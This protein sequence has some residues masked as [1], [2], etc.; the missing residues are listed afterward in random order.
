MR[1]SS[2]I[3]IVNTYV[4]LTGGPGA[5]TDNSPNKGQVLLSSHFRDEENE[6]RKVKRFSQGL[7]AQK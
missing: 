1:V 4:P 6:A 7:L 2:L 3:I 5:A